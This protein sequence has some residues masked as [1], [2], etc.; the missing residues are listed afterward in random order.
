MR[1][2]SGLIT[3]TRCTY[4]PSQMTNRPLVSQILKSDA[5]VLCIF[6]TS[7]QVTNSSKVCPPSLKHRYT[8]YIH[9][10]QYHRPSASPSIESP[11]SLRAR[12]G[13]GSGQKMSNHLLAFFRP[14]PLVPNSSS[15]GRPGDII[16][17]PPCFFLLALVS[18]RSY[19]ESL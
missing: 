5:Y 14:T 11:R 1:Y 12:C 15:V 9:M 10:L 3:R 2:Q 7:T 17:S 16:I 18:R 19:E 8:Q 6:N 13:I 4:S